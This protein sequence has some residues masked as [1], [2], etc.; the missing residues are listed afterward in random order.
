MAEMLYRWRWW[1]WGAFVAAWTVALLVSIP[2]SGVWDIDTFK[3]KPRFFFAKGLHISAYAF[4]AALSAW[5]RVPIRYRFVLIFFLMAHASTTEL[6]QWLMED[7]AGRG[8]SLMDVALDN[9]GI[10]LGSW[11][12]W[13][14]WTE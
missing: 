6:L 5:L 1:I 11:W 13:R 14:W 7:I 3:V 4:L 10:A 8:G 9:I 12:A 2:P